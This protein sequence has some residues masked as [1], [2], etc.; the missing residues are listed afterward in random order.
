M[1]RKEIVTEHGKGVLRV[2]P[3]QNEV[4]KMYMRM[5]SSLPA[6]LPASHFNSVIKLFL[7]VEAVW[8]TT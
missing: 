1:I 7:K 2:E 8:K 4:Y 3:V 6:C 5:Y